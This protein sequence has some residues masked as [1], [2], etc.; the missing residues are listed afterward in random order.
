MWTPAN[1]V[2]FSKKKEVKQC[3]TINKVHNQSV[4][5]IWPNEATNLYVHVHENELAT[6]SP[7]NRQKILKFLELR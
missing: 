6:A 3:T 4:C 7:K 1:V 5:Q 2:Y